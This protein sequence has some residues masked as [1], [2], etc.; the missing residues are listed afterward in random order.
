MFVY[1]A[2]THSCTCHRLGECAGV[3]SGYKL[4]IALHGELASARNGYL[5][6]MKSVGFHHKPCRHAVQGISLFH[7]FL[8]FGHKLCFLGLATRESTHQKLC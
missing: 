8:L 6:S 7:C 3:S 2:L 1:V 4:A 5:D